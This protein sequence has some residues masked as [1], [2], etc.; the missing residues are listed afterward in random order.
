MLRRLHQFLFSPKQVPHIGKVIAHYLAL[1]EPICLDLGSADAAFR[2]YIGIDMNPGADIVH[3]LTKGIPFP[4]ASVDKIRSDHFIEHLTYL[5]VM[6]VFKECYRV[7][8]KDSCMDITIP[9]FDAYLDA[10]LKKDSE[11]L[12]KEIYDIPDEYKNI[13]TK[14]FDMVMWVIVRNGEHKSFFDKD[15]IVAKLADA[16]F[17]HIEERSHDPSIDTERRFSSLYMRGYK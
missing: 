4:D 17:S 3:D 8:K 11:L 1:N 16:G 6:F 7:L 5:E 10:Y 13:L 2:G 12:S 15:S 14:P 9:C